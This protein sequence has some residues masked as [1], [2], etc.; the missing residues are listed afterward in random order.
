MQSWIKYLLIF[1]YVLTG[2][3]KNNPEPI[4]VPVPWSDRTVLVYMVGEN[5]LSRW[6]TENLDKMLKTFQGEGNLMVYMDSYEGVPQLVKAVM[7]DNGIASAEIVK[8]YEERN[9]ASPDIL[10]ETIEEVCL[11]YPA[12]SYGLVLWSHGTGWLPSTL[13][14]RA[15]GQDGNNW[16]ELNDLASALPDGRF[17]FILFDACYMG[18]VEIAY[19]LRNKTGYLI[20]SP[21][22]IWEDGFPYDEVVGNWWGG[23]ESYREVCRKF[24]D[25][26]NSREGIRKSGTISLVKTENMDALAE[27]TRVILQGKDE[28]IANLDRSSIQRIDRTGSLIWDNILYDFDDYISHLSPTAEQYDIFSRELDKVILYEAHTPSYGNQIFYQKF[29]GLSSYIPQSRQ[30][31]LNTFYAGLEWTQTVYDTQSE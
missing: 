29:C 13:K 18:C 24:Y 10:K 5:S 12:S 8:T 9:S 23:E 21:A 19:A 7:N 30:T 22:E 2:C 27:A 6:T 31:W 25:F 28:Q 16:M 3:H 20:S 15:F 4:P 14:S 17:D 1:C 11:E 26:Y